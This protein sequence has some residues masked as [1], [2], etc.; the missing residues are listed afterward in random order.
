LRLRCSRDLKT[1]NN[2]SSKSLGT[3]CHSIW[4]RDSHKRWLW[5]GRESDVDLLRSLGN[6]ELRPSV[7]GMV[8]SVPAL[9][10]QC[11]PHCL[12]MTAETE[13]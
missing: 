5:K 11:K 9:C 13:L 10:G 8:I 12:R 6:R 4:L 3:N 1:K 7:K 2:Y